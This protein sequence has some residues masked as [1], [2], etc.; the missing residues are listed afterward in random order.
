[1]DLWNYWVKNWRD[2]YGVDNIRWK[3]TVGIGD[4][5]YGMNIA[6]MRAFVNQKPTKLQI[7]YHFP[8]NHYYHY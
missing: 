5:M 1:M 6:Y 7:H 8:E 3:T 2:N 4:S